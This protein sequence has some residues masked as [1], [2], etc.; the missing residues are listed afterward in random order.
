MRAICKLYRSFDL[1]KK[2]GEREK[3]ERLILRN[4]LHIWFADLIINDF[5]FD[6]ALFRTSLHCISFLAF[7][8][9]FFS[10]Y[11]CSCQAYLKSLEF[12]RTIIFDWQ[13]IHSIDKKSHNFIID[14]FDDSNYNNTFQSINFFALYRV[15]IVINRYSMYIYVH[16]TNIWRKYLIIL[17]SIP[18]AEGLFSCKNL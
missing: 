12:H 4:Y 14:N 15:H 11:L 9:S 7:N 18:F 1:I 13:K 5:I 16:L 10:L 6:N 2:N 17:L 3:I 8:S